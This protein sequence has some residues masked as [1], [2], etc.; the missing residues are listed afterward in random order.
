MSTEIISAFI[1]GSN[2]ASEIMFSAF[3]YGKAIEPGLEVDLIL[4]L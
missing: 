3:Q 4:V 2:T 1:F